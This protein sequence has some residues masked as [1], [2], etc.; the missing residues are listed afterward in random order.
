[1]VSSGLTELLGLVSY[2]ALLPKGVVGK[3]TLLNIVRA[4]ITSICTIASLSLVPS[5]EVWILG[6]VFV[7]VFTVAALATKLISPNDFLAVL[8][9]RRRN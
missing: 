8:K 3:A 7:L 5:Q 2:V 1:M 9:Y 6:P 4:G